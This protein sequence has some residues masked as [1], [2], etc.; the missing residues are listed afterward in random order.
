M[1]L[2]NQKQEDLLK[3][4]RRLMNDLQLALGR[5]GIE[6]EDQ[7]ALQQSIQQLDEIFLIVVVGEFNSG[8][9]AMI[10]A[11]LG[12]RLLEEGV[13]PTTTKIHLLRHGEKQQR[14]VISERQILLTSPV[15]F[16]SEISIR[17]FHHSCPAS[18]GEN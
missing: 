6:R 16:L 10:N 1:R 7:E 17:P 3:D 5:F 14:T 11:L 2:L 12:Q 4:E 13:T 8:K 15:E 9:S 18:A